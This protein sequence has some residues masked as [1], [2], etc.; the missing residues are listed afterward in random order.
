MRLQLIL[1]FILSSLVSIAQTPEGK[2]EV[3]IIKSE[4]YKTDRK[5]AIYL[6]PYY[7]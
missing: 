2:K 1:F 6:P 4:V 7:E 3:L 5:I